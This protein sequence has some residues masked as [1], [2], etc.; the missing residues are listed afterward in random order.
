MLHEILDN[1]DIIRKSDAGVAHVG[2]MGCCFILRPISLVGA[3]LVHIEA[4]MHTRGSYADT[5]DS[6]RDW[7]F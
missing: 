3:R 1:V 7:K 4:H 6:L 5:L 2:G